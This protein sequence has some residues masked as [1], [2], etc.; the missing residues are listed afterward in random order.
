MKTIEIQI[1]WRCCE[2]DCSSFNMR[3]TNNCDKIV[4]LQNVEFDGTAVIGASC[5]LYKEKDKQNEKS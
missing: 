2:Q 4:S 3:N 1:D 5:N